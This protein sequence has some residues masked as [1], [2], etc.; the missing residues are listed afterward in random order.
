L[1]DKVS[2]ILNSQS[3]RER[4]FFDAREVEQEFKAHLNGQKNIGNIILRWLNLELWL[5]MF[6]DRP[7][8]AT[9]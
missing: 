8:A 6:I 4:S 5:R 9:T 1:G 7:V 2:E 3:F